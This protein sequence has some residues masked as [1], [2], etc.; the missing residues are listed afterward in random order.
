MELIGTI[1]LPGAIVFT[2]WLVVSGI[3]SRQPQILPLTMLLL[4]LFLPGFLI[5]ITTK[6]RIYILYMLV[7]MTALPIWNFVLPLYSFWHF[8]DFRYTFEIDYSWGETRKVT[9]ETGHDHSRRDG[10]YTVGSVPMKRFIL[11]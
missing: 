6:K 9:G 2:I 10:R 11:Y 5:L 4:V 1:V 8:D 7:Y 3:I